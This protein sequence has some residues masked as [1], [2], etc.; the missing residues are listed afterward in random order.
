MTDQSSMT[1]AGRSKELKTASECDMGGC[2]FPDYSRDEEVRDEATRVAGDRGR[3]LADADAAGVAVDQPR[4]DD[5]EVAVVVR[6]RVELL[7]DV[8]PAVRAG[9]FD[10]RLAADDHGDV[11]P[12]AREDRLADV[13]PGQRLE[14]GVQE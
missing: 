12:L 13:R 7:E 1:M 8:G 5:G 10:H 6:E 3:V 14:R 2:S 4:A 9:G 11:G